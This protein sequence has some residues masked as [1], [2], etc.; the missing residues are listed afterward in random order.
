MLY[1]TST[2][3]AVSGAT[4]RQL[5]YWTRRGVLS[6]SVG[7]KGSGSRRAWSESDMILAA[8][9]A[10]VSA[11]FRYGEGGPMIG[12]ALR[13]LIV[14]GDGDLPSRAVIDAD[15]RLWQSG[16]PTTTVMMLIDVR[17]VAE[18]TRDR[19]TRH[20]P[21]DPLESR[22]RRVAVAAS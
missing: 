15:G 16:D 1:G 14:H 11:V 6:P 10:D 20:K 4:M 18:R 5:D 7:A 19:L 22:Y 8:C 2:A 21:V 17:E 13:E 3:I 12:H 9:I